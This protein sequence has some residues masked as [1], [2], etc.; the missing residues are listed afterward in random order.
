MEEDSDSD[1][2]QQ[3]MRLLLPLGDSD[4]CDSECAAAAQLDGST[5]AATCHEIVVSPDVSLRVSTHAACGI[6]WQ[7]WPAAHV[8]AEYACLNPQLWRG[9]RVCELGAG[10]GLTGLRVACLG[11]HVTLTDLPDVTEGVL[12]DNAR[13]NA[14]AIAACGGGSVQVAPL[15]WGDAAHIAALCSGDPWDVL[16]CADVVYRRHLI[17]PLIATLRGMATKDTLVVIAH[18]KRFKLEADFWK[19]LHRHFTR[20]EVHVEAHPQAGQRRPVRVYTCRLK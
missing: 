17:A 2:E 5:T 9:A 13:A 1:A 10:C 19:Q 15:A 11:A 4:D 6:A 18:L 12:N 20:E 8:A 7:L 16:L 14:D 3:A